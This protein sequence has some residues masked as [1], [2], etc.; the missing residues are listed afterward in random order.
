MTY[1]FLKNGSKVSQSLENGII[2]SGLLG[3]ML[4]KL[5]SYI[6]GLGERGQSLFNIFS[7]VTEVLM[8]G[9][10]TAVSAPLLMKLMFWPKGVVVGAAGVTGWGITRHPAPLAILHS[11]Q[12]FLTLAYKISEEK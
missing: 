11:C 9:L 2:I 3:K 5:V 12:Q 10:R 4:W 6:L 1:E 8:L 7:P